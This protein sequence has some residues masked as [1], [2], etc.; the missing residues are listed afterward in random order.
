MYKVFAVYILLR[1]LAFPC[2][3]DRSIN[4]FSNARRDFAK[5]EKVGRL[6]ETVTESSGLTNVAG[7]SN[8]ITLNDGGNPPEIFI[9]NQN[10]GLIQQVPITGLKNHDWESVTMDNNGNL[11]IGDFGNNSNKRKDLTII[12]YNTLNKTTSKIQL[13]YPDQS[14]FP[15]TPSELNFDCEAMFWANDL[16]YLISKNRGKGPVR[17]YSV[18]SQEGKYTA[19]LVDSITIKGMI[20]GVDY[21]AEKK[22]LALLS[23]GYIY[24]F[25]VQHAVNFKSPISVAYYGRLAQSEG[26]TY[27]QN[28]LLISNEAGKLFRLKAKK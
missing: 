7:S 12:K 28:D 26:I 15:P 17:L 21:N 10:G 22:E 9:L 25:N 27:L 4:N 1:S 18:P 6:P 14:E 8:V 13:S 19:T 3:K 11:Y 5:L 2:H 16:L 23:Y 24:I 20:T